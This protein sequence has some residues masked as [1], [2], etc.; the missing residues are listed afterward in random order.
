M[1]MNYGMCKLKNESC[2]NVHPSYIRTV[3]ECDIHWLVT[4]NGLFS[5]YSMCMHMISYKMY[6]NYI[7]YC[8]KIYDK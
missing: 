6:Y 2:M 8:N 5:T 3:H 4:I 7:M 1:G